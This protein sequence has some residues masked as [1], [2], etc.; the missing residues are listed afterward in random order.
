MLTADAPQAEVNL[1][2]SRSAP[3]TGMAEIHSSP[4]GALVRVDGIAVGQTP[5]RQPLRVGDTRRR[6]G[7]GRLRAVVGP[8]GRAG[9]GTR[10]RR[11]ACCARWSRATPTPEPV[12]VARVYAPAEV[13]TQ[14]RRLAG[15]AAP[16]PSERAPPAARAAT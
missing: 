11:R 6:A 14:P 9:R 15:S 4:P 13:D 10:A 8:G 1:T 12:D 3:A 16:Y 2:L 5:L 7:E